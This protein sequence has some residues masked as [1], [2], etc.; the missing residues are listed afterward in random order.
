M[1]PSPIAAVSLLHHTNYYATLY[2]F[3]YHRC[4]RIRRW[5]LGN[6]WSRHT[7]G[8]FLHITHRYDTQNHHYHMEL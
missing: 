6:D 7:L 2:Y 1:V 5:S 3:A 4:S 8:S